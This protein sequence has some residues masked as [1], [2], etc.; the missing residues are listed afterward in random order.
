MFTRFS[1]R[2][3]QRASRAA[4]TRWT[5]RRDLQLAPIA[6]QRSRLRASFACVFGGGPEGRRDEGA[7]TLAAF[8]EGLCV[9]QVQ[10]KRDDL[11]CDS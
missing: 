3:R 6:P 2:P 1:Q 9:Y 8:N 11:L 5:R 7:H 4:E 10:V